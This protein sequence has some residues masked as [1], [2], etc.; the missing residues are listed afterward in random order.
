[1]VESLL[2]LSLATHTWPEQ[3][4]LATINPLPNFDAPTEYQEFRCFEKVVHRKF[5]KNIVE[6]KLSPTQFAYRSGCSRISDPAIVSDH[7]EIGL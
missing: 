6:D 1:M 3:W 5:V 2:H 7:M 4:K